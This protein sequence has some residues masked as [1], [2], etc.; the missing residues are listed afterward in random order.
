MGFFDFLKGRKPKPS[1]PVARHGSA[2]A[3]SLFGLRR[4][5]QE[6]A[7]YK[8][9]G[10]RLHRGSAA[11]LPDTLNVGTEYARDFLDGQYTAVV[12]SW[13]AGAVYQEAT[14]TL[15]IDFL[16]GG[17][18]KVEGVSLAEAAD[19][20]T[21]SPGHGEWVHDHVLGRPWHHGG[22]TLKPVTWFG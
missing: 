21:A 22:P 14:E 17:G 1:A 9:F 5:H 4:A 10:E 7:K 18:M 12:S 6:R 13:H 11:G 19:Y 3:K 16:K 8:T 2:A 20:I 15:V